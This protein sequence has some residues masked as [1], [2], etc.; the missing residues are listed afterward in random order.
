M[1][2]AA[3]Q[4]RPRIGVP[5]NSPDTAAKAGIV[6][7]SLTAA[8]EAAPGGVRVNCV[9]CANIGSDM[10]RAAWSSLG[11]SEERILEHSPVGWVGTPEAVAN[12]A[13]LSLLGRGLVH[14]R[15]HA[16]GRRG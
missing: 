11:V 13:P 9:L 10:A 14:H 1:V 7:L 8:L 3:S 4:A 15:G 5:T 2:N 6:G 12:A 16:H